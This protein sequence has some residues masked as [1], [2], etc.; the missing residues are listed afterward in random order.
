MDDDK[1]SRQQLL[2]EIKALRRQIADGGNTESNICES[3]EN[4][5]LLIGNVPASLAVFD[6]NGTF[7]FVNEIAASH[8][9]L[10]PK[11]I[12]NRNHHEFFPPEIADR[13]MQ[14]IRQVI[15]TGNAF[16][17]ETRTLVNGEWRWFDVNLQPFIDSDGRTAAAL[18]I[19][20]DITTRRNAEEELRES[21][22][23]FRELVEKAGIAILADDR[24]GHYTYFNDKLC[25]LFGYTND[26]MQQQSIRTLV[27]PDDLE[28]VLKYHYDRI[29][30]LDSVSRYE[31]KGIRKDGSSIFLEIDVSP[32]RVEEKI[33]G[34]RSYVWDIT[35]RRRA[36]ETLRENEQFY[37]AVIKNSPLGISVRDSKGRLLNY[38]EAW[39][40]LW[41]ISENEIEKL[42]LSPR[43]TLRL[44][45]HDE[46]LGKWKPLV[47]RIYQKGGYLFIP[48]VKSSHHRSGI[49][50][51]FSQYFYALKDKSGN[52]DKVIVLTEDITD[53][54]KAEVALQQS[55]RQFRELTDLLPQTVFEVD[56]EG[57]VTFANRHGFES[58]GY[59]QED[60]D[61][62]LF[63][64]QLVIPEDRERILKN[65]SMRI[66]GGDP[67]DHEYTVQRKDG[68]T[69]PVL[70]YSAAIIR[71]NKM[72]GLRG[73][74]VDITMRKEAEMEIKKHRDHLEELVR[75]RSSELIEANEK[76]RA[77]IRERQRTEAEVRESGERY[78]VLFETAGEGILIAEYKTRIFHYANPAICRF[79]GY[80]ADELAGMGVNDVHPS[81]RM[82]EIHDEFERNS[83]MPQ[84]IAENI[85]CL[86]KDGTIVF[87]DIVGAT[88]YIDGVR[89]SVGFFRDITERIRGREAIRESE[90]R[91]RLLAELS[92]NAISIVRD[93]RIV[94]INKTGIQLYGAEK[95]EDIL[96]RE[97]LDFIHPEYRELVRAKQQL[98]LD[99]NRSSVFKEE[100]LIRLDGQV[101]T[102]DAAAAPFL[103][104]GK[105]A[106][107]V[108]ARDITERK[109]IEEALRDS[110]LQYRTTI[111]SMGDS[112][113]VI[114]QS[115]RVILSN[116][117]LREWH[118]TIGINPDIHGKHLLE[119]YPFL[120]EKVIEEYKQVFETGKILV[121]V[122]SNDVGGKKIVTE[123]RKIPI[124]EGNRVMRIVTVLRDITQRVLA[125]EALRESETWLRS[126][127]ESLPF[128][129]F[130]LDENGRYILQNSVCRRHWGDLIGTNP[131]EAE[132]DE[133]IKQIW[134]E[135]NRRAL[136][137]ETVE[138]EVD[139]EF[140]G[141]IG[142]YFNIIAPIFYKGKIRGILG[143]NMDITDRRRAEDKLLKA[144]EEL[145][146]ERE[147]LESKNT[148]LREIMNQ[149]EL[150][151]KEINLK[152]AGNID[153][154]ILPAIQRLRETCGEPLRK[155]VDSIESSLKT[156][157][158]PFMDQIHKKYSQLSPRE[159]EICDMIK[160]GMRSKDMAEILNVS[161]LT[162][163]KHR[164]T[165]RKKLGIK[166]KGVNLSSHLQSF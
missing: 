86:R 124:S 28:R 148:A 99:E 107:Q 39:K 81:E 77:E 93:G 5:R 158:S 11:D 72:I 4:Y 91:F 15:D 44:D 33:V 21:E 108:V 31:F 62:G 160:K 157:S 14:N 45:E 138:G 162:I 25:E 73:I 159:L 75:E 34:T 154:L 69:F 98:V 126:T 48:E 118:N 67:Q 70:I 144:T 22:E 60:I 2:D 7:L 61:K 78:R 101:V 130:A 139:Y 142:H 134:V 12:I 152:I 161:V 35:E 41:G 52:V 63:V 112:V 103:Y 116:K 100:K 53:R 42:Y 143:L 96:G 47:T 92:P 128:D 37:S 122:E 123:T 71:D 85:P 16:S 58:T 110:E 155:Q 149:I 114:N 90:E 64:P 32:L 76:L 59:T 51:W 54:R 27:H 87:A 50:R 151:K 29:N 80:S 117:A 140:E 150:E 49:P 137:G 115:Y 136:N 30:G 20:N 135:N 133:D 164:E 119:A 89:Y 8:W 166:N 106:I 19:A 9:G 40:K 94:F 24:E 36:E 43:S 68:S 65:I 153:R 83:K 120:T 125:E 127:V 147:A 146:S 156:I 6:Y 141:Q 13:Q 26:E 46:Y 129:F 105:P 55:E 104:Q 132:V 66:A 113:H 163:H 3:S 111:D 165:I 1:K 79:L 38:N 10:A 88:I 23:R 109:R 145:R 82:P 95:A 121:T 84:Y 56:L 131:A 74:T 18:L 17:E 57:R 102:V 97:S